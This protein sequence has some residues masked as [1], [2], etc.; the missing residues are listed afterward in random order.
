[1]SLR[2][3]SSVAGKW[4][5]FYFTIKIYIL[6]IILTLPHILYSPFRFCAQKWEGSL[7]VLGTMYAYD[8]FAATPCCTERLKV[9]KIIIVLIIISEISNVKCLRSLSLLL[10][11][12]FF[13]Y[14]LFTNCI[15]HTPF[16]SP[17]RRSYSV[18]TASNY[19]SIHIIVSTSTA[20]IRMSSHVSIAPLRTHTLLSRCL[21]ATPSSH[22]RPSSSGHNMRPR[23]T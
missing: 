14:D 10:C 6:S 2:I 3:V 17:P 9:S 18:T 19:C 11:L 15:Y 4:I 13:V 7:L 16:H 5:S 23:W 8:I 1:M 22:Y 21:S 20:T 12:Y